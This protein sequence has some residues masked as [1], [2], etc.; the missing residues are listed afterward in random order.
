MELGSQVV[1]K[2]TETPLYAASSVLEDN[3]DSMNN[4]WNVAEKRQQYVDE[5]ILVALAFLGEHTQRRQN[6]SQN[7]LAN[8]STGECHAI[9]GV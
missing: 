3:V 8:V 5:E 9:Y 1:A 6:Y 4:T 7:K 2:Q